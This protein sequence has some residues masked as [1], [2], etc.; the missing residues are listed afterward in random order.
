MTE[1]ATPTRVAQAIGRA[2][3]EHA[4]FGG[5]EDTGLGLYLED[6]LGNEDT[7]LHVTEVGPE[8]ENASN[9]LMS[10]FTIKTS[11]GREWTIRVTPKA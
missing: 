11:D 4:N 8:L 7:T 5:H 10:Q 9:G 3:E 6:G 1:R 2:I